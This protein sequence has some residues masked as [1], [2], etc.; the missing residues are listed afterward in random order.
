[1]LEVDLRSRTPNEVVRQGFKVIDVVERI[2]H[3]KLG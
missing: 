1:M 2:A 3:M